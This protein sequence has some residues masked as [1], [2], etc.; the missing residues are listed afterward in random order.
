MAAMCCMAVMAEKEI[1][2]VFDGVDKLTIFYDENRESQG[3]VLD[4]WNESDI[5]SATTSVEFDASIVDARPTSTSRWFSQFDALTTIVNIDKLN[6]EE[7]TDMSNMFAQCDKLSSL[8]VSGFNTEKVTNMQEMFSGCSNLW[9]LN[10]SAW[11]TENVE[12]MYGMF[13]YCANLI[14]IGISGWNTSKVK[15]MMWM[16]NNCSS[17]TDLDLSGWNTENVTNMYGMFTFCESL[18]TLNL[19]GWNT[20]KVENMQS[21][22]FEC[23][24]L[25][26]LDLSSFDTKNVTD[27]SSMFAYCEN[28]K[29]LN[30][31]GFDTKNVTDMS[32]MFEYC[33]NLKTLNLSGFDTKNV[34]DMHEMF[35]SCS[36]LPSLD[37]SSFNTSNVTEMFWMF[38]YCDAIEYLNLS[39]FNAENVISLMGMFQGCKALTKISFDNFNTSKAENMS[40]MFHDCAKLTF[41]PIDFIHFDTRNVEDM[42]H[43]FDNCKAVT[44]LD[45]RSF[46]MEKVTNVNSMF[47]SCENL[48]T[49]ICNSDW[50][51]LKKLDLSVSM[52]KG[53]TKLVGGGGTAYDEA[54]PKD[55][56]YARIDLNPLTYGYFTGEAELYSVYDAEEKTLTYYF[57]FERLQRK[58][59]IDLVYHRRH[60]EEYCDDAEKVIVDPSVYDCGMTVVTNLFHEFVGM[61]MT[62]LHKVQKIEGLE[63]LRTDIVTNFSNMFYDMQ[64]L[65][66]LLLGSF[67]MGNALTVKSMFHGCSSLKHVELSSFSNTKKVIDFSNMFLDCSSLESLD[68]R[69]FNTESAENMGYM[70]AGCTSL[71]TLDLSYFNTENVRYMYSMFAECTSLETVSLD[72][73]R[74]M[75]I[76]HFDEM[77]KNCWSLKT[78]WIDDDWSGFGVPDGDMFLGCT[79]LIGGEG[80]VFDDGH[81]NSEYARMDGGPGYEGYFSKRSTD[82]QMY[83][84]FDVASSTLTFYYDEYFYYKPY[85][86]ATTIPELVDDRVILR[87][88][89]GDVNYIIFDASFN[90]ARPTVGGN[91]FHQLIRDEEGKV[92][93][94]F[95]TCYATSISGWEY[96]HTDEMTD[97]SYLFAYLYNIDLSMLDLTAL[98]TDQATDMN[99][100]FSSLSATTSIDLSGFNTENVTDMSHMF[101][102]CWMVTS[103]DLSK[104]RTDKV[105]NMSGMFNECNGLTALDLKTFET[106]QVTDM[107]WMFRSCDGLTSLDI[108]HFN[109]E[110]VTDMS[111]MFEYCNGLTSLDV[112]QLNTG[113]VRDMSYMFSGCYGVPE[114]DVSAF[115]TDSVRSMQG[116][117]SGCNGL[118]SLDL[119]K[120]V[121]DS[122]T[123]FAFMFDNCYNLTSL[124]FSSFNT[125]KVTDMR[126]MF[127]YCAGLTSLN[128][129]TF[130]TEKVEDMGAMFSTCSS[131]KKLDLSGFYTPLLKDA[132][133]MFYDCNKIESLNLRSFKAENIES[134]AYMFADCDH[135]RYV[136]ISTFGIDHLEEVEYAFQSCP[137]LKTIVCNE[138]WNGNEVLTAESWRSEGI[139]ADCYG[140]EGQLGSLYTDYT[141]DL[142]DPNQHLT[143]ARMDQGD[144][145]PGFFTQ[146]FE[147]KF[148]DGDGFLMK[149]DTVVYGEAAT[150]PETTPTKEGYHFTGWDKAFTNVKEDI[151]VTA[152]Y[153]VN[154]YKVT[155]IAEHGEITYEPSETDLDKVNHGTTLTLIAGGDQGY[156]LDKWISGDYQLSSITY[157]LT[158]TSDTTVTA[159]FKLQ[160]FTV[161]F[162]DSDNNPIGEPQIVEYGKSAEAPEA[163]E[164]EGMHFSN[165]SVD[166]SDVKSDLEV[167]AIYSINT[168]KVT[169]IAE[170]GSI[171]V[172]P[173]ETS[174]S[175]VEHGSELVLTAT[176][177]QGYEFVSWTNYD[178]E[179][180]VV[181]SDTTVTANFQIQT[182]EVKFLDING[183]QIGET[184]IIEW[185]QAA[186]EPKAPEVEGYDFVGWD[187]EFEHVKEDLS[188]QAQYQI[189]TFTVKFQD[190]FGNTI[191][192]EVVEWDK[193]ATAPDAPEKE[194]YHFIGWSQ[195]YTHVH[196][197]M[198][199]YAKYEI[200]TYKVTIIAEHGS[201]SVQPKEIDLDKVEHGMVL[202]LEAVPDEGYEFAGWTNYNGSLL[203]VTS[204]TTVTA[205]FKILTFTVTFLGFG[206]VE[207]DQQTVE[208]NQAA[209][210][211][212]APEVEG[213]EFTGWDKA[214]DQVTEDLT[215]KA[216]YAEVTDYTPQNLNA[217]LEDKDGNVQITLS[218]DKVDGI[219]SYELR[220]LNGEEEL[221]SRN[222]FGQN[223]IPTKLSDLVKEYGIKPG[224]YTIHWFVRSTDVMGTAVSEWA[225]GPEFEITV[226]DTGTG[227][228]E[229]QSDQIQSTKV[230]REGVIYILRDGKIYD[231][232]GKKVE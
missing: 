7:V 212:E 208:W 95:G 224:S 123:S 169:L 48:T 61:T 160:T 176:P 133:N 58:G 192:T 173:K 18:N 47:E 153:A 17:I 109:T 84:I 20:E 149:T 83:T 147:V 195:D 126:G 94:T 96:L 37:L 69:S 134:M 79:N 213:Y 161:T 183:E 44:E 63:N 98:K 118:S 70:F 225:E 74:L 59:I 124:D 122:C 222:T 99:H 137:Q 127:I 76:T 130:N 30:L 187:K 87:D 151:S 185:N 210:A 232:N 156:E 57:D 226:K 184:Q 164:V 157:K 3:G 13:H 145:Y 129:S 180:L 16:F 1:Y 215:V 211:P 132:S 115:K 67:Y 112:S 204:D 10:L 106:D 207:L 196:E 166:F 68:V 85:D 12:N 52:F 24:K 53:C 41:T 49:I 223:V 60:F 152:Q 144:Y 107:S 92:T 42:S 154:T 80:T 103:L 105:T 36:S 177:E 168:Y 171:S 82:K 88:Y 172:Y 119:S 104:F 26:S 146:T 34:T 140:L 181:T 229:V 158:V 117:F 28:L 33:E 14:P 66:T 77:F 190:S 219:P 91:L 214:F 62:G 143:F 6:T 31:S 155:L 5:Q 56:T 108:N 32:S 202:A 186:D 54:N 150:A 40:Y 179:K 19:S 110:N 93:N 45:L 81:I 22:F 218:W 221:F 228:D 136:D 189:K 35:R 197:D 142:A 178:G 141:I 170:N 8:D 165:W 162:F 148:F 138:N 227:V 9:S 128:L 71:K 220:V 203:T 15:N 38:R 111:H 51:S 2:G 199:V 97:M 230:M 193:S 39:S 209:V 21:M 159:A 100:L 163:P 191:K 194:G 217:E 27:M 182:F 46:N 120:F 121:T 72:R 135:L 55:K 90:D 86:P 201:V 198:S 206:D 23:T 125:E 188:V 73:F 231:L 131:M 65:D 4:W 43:M 102:N 29:T 174:L 167:S 78:I 11:N 101:D 50:N 89:G 175:I 216:V 139:F 205:N 25:T 200:N 64:S 113:M 114:L 116:M 75:S